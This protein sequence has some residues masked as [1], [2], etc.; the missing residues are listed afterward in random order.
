MFKGMLFDLQS[1][2]VAH[3]EGMGLLQDGADPQEDM[4]E[5]AEGEHPRHVAV[6]QGGGQGHL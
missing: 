4:E 3:L 6:P 2:D 5:G 1:T